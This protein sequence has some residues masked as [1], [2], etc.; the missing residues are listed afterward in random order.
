VEEVVNRALPG[1]GFK[2]KISQA[3]E[4][5]KC[6][7]RGKTILQLKGLENHPVSNQYRALATEIEERV[8]HRDNFIAGRMTAPPTAG[9]EKTPV[10]TENVGGSAAVI[11]GE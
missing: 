10:N 5:A 6:A 4:V 3:I 11:A 8:T 9:S 7:G 2:T 1:R